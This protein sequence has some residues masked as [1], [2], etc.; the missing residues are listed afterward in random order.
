[1][2]LRE[3]F[4]NDLIEAI[5]V[6]HY[7]S[8]IKNTIIKA[9]AATLKKGGYVYN[10]MAEWQHRDVVVTQVIDKM[11][12]LEHYG[13]DGLR[14]FLTLSIMRELNS[15]LAKDLGAAN[16]SST[17]NYIEW[18]SFQ[19]LSG[20][21]HGHAS[22]HNITLNKKLYLDPLVESI[23][24]KIQ[25]IVV[26]SGFAHSVNPDDLDL[27][28]AQQARPQ[29][30]YR[31]YWDQ[32]LSHLD[33][34]ADS[35]AQDMA[36]RQQSLINDMVDTILHELVHVIQ[37]RR[38]AHRL[39]DLEYRSYLDRK[40]GELKNLYRGPEQGWAYGDPQWQRLYRASPQEIAAFAHNMAGQI[41]RAFGLD[42]P[43]EEPYPTITA[44]DFVRELRKIVGNQYRDPNNPQERAVLNRYLKLAYQEVQRY[45]ERKKQAKN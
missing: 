15:V 21:E 43:L 13:Q 3:L 41:I 29:N 14:N 22:R 1:M 32:I 20:N 8:N 16:Y 42:E 12:P 5:S 36:E 31:V 11:T 4:K 40:K 35:I 23:I 44:A 38:Q 17:G 19:E 39:G 2:L 28:P 18:I 45:L 7:E 24:D 27:T 30:Y 25:D 34:N 10:H 6:S 37:H 26:G 33:R 9:I